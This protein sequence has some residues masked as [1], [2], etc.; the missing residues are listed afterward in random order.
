MSLS[1]K[2]Y[3]VV[4]DTNVLFQNY[5]KKADFTTFSFNSTFKNIIDMINQL[6]IYEQVVI[7]IPEVTWNEMKKQI[8][9][10][11]AEKAE[12]FKSYVKKWIFPEY[13]ISE[14]KIE[15]YRIFIEKKI[16]LYKQEIQTGINKIVA[17]PIPS[18]ERFKGIVQRAFNKAPPFGGKKRILIKGSKTFLYG[19]V[20]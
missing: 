2:E 8:I 9:D 11:H 3:F 6:D 20:Y 12:A 7:V 4:F 1:K 19:K 16:D 10:A 17:L 18:D 15:D 5:D 14:V 13:S